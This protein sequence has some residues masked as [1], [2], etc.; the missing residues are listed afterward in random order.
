MSVNYFYH[1]FYA[2]EG[3][4]MQLIQVS[5]DFIIIYFINFIIID[6]MIY[7]SIL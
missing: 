6:L 2:N 7:H 4:N 5:I 3:F 1:D